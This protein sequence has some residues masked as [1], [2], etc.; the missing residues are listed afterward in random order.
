MSKTK[1]PEQNSIN[2]LRGSA[3]VASSGD[4]LVI[5]GELAQKCL[6]IAGVILVVINARQEVSYINKAGC[7]ILECKQG[8]IIGKNWFDNFIPQGIR[9]QLRSYFE[10]LKYVNNNVSLDLEQKRIMDL[11][12]KSYKDR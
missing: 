1:S 12:I 6:D 3:T 2:H 8:E 10:K 4:E 11:R 5:Q 9:E 7:R